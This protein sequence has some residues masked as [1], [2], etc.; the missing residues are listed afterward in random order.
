[1]RKQMLGTITALLAIVLMAQA[2]TP[3]AEAS[4]AALEKV[5][6]ARVATGVEIEM[7]TR[8][9]VT[10]KV[11]TLSSPARLVVDL[12]NTVL[13]T[14]VN[15]IAVGKTGVTGVRVGRDASSTTRVVVD[16]DR[17]CKYELVPG[18][19]D[20]LTLKIQ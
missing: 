5:S 6:V 16:M 11:E 10:P 1:M 8:G 9:A 15:R 4:R 19:G 18:P 20:K 7:T 13:A 12:P 17:L 14:S 3:G 2:Q